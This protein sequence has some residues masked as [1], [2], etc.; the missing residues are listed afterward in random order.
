M[1]SYLLHRLAAA[2]L[3]AGVAAAVFLPTST[4]D[5]CSRVALFN[6]SS[7]GDMTTRAIVGLTAALGA[8]VIYTLGGLSRRTR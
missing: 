8:L 3:F 6:C 4:I 1:S 2:V 5:L 7:Q